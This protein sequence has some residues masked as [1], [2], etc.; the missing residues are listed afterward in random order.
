M[1]G[2]GTISS[3]AVPYTVRVHIYVDFRRHG[4]SAEIDGPAPYEPSRP[5]PTTAGAGYP[6]AAHLR[7]DESAHR[8]V[9]VTLGQEE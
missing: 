4:R 7:Y 6:G 9:L 2:C 8:E 1:G 5:G 3:V